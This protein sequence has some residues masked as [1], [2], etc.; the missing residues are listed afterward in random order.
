MA[1]ALDTPFATAAP[2]RPTIRT[3][4]FAVGALASLGAGGIH[5]AAIG[6]HGEHRQAVY[7]F[8]VVALFQIGVGAMALVSNRKLVGLALG[9]GNLALVGGWLLA[10]TSS[11]GIGFID[12]LDAKEPIQWADGLAVG[13]AAVA[14]LVVL[15]AAFRRWHLPSSDA[16]TRVFA[17]PVVALTLTGM[18]AAGQ[19][20][21]SHGT[22]A[23]GHVHAAAAIPPT[24]FVPG[25]PIN[26]GGV[27]GVTAAQQAQAENV[28]ASTLYFLPHFS[29]YKV[30]EAEGWFSIG[31]GVS[32]FEH[33]IKPSTFD[34]GKVLDPTAPESLVYNTAGGKRTLSAAMYMLSTGT[35]LAD[36]PKLGGA[37]MQWHIHDNLC[38]SPTGHIAGLRAAGGPCPVGQVKGGETPMI[39]VW[40][41]SNPCGPFSALEG[42]G[43]GSIAPGETR[44]CD[45]V[46][47][48]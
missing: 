18:V 28:L 5:A 39:H 38:F 37:L 34:D 29:D 4:T 13:L 23:A 2:A 43:A 11:S 8:A 10:K 14:V 12:G 32:G 20:T 46:H 41:K 21:H 17:L 33:F 47:G 45:H 9:L 31:D 19:H 40:V 7:T 36:V 6:A 15:I 1:L 44:L 22:A 25:Q 42:I 30:A 27:P 35:T 3:G 16:I 48:A 24:P 26:L